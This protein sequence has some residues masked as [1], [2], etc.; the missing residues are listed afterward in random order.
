MTEPVRERLKTL[1]ARPG[2]YLMRDR[3]G[4]IVYVG[5]A[6]NLR[7]RVTGYFRAGAKHPPKVRSMVDT[8]WDFSFMTVKNEAEALL[9]EAALIKQHRPRFNIL[10]RDDKRYLALR[11]DTD[12]RWPRFSLTRTVRRDGA[13]Y[14]GPF[15]SGAAVRAAKDFAE[16]RF[17]IRSCKTPE[18]DAATHAHCLDDVVRTCSA[19]CIGK[20]CEAEYRRR[21]AEAC[22][23]LDGRR[24]AAVAEVADGMRAAS[25]RG[26]FE[27]AARL[28]DAWLALKEFGKSH[29]VRKPPGARREDAMRGLRELAD[30]LGLPAPPRTIECAD[31]SNLFGTYNV[32]SL[33]VAR[34]GLPDGRF[35]RRFRIS[36]FE[37]AD[38]PRA[39]AEV[40]RR[41][42]GPDST[43]AA[44]SPRAD[45]FICDGGI[46]QLNA[47]RAVFEE[48]GMGDMPAVG[49]AER[50]EEIVFDDGRPN[51]MLPRDSEALFVCTRLRD[52]AHR[53]AISYH[54]RLRGK[55]LRESVLDEVYG[56]GEAKKAAL[57]RH[58][59]SLAG[60][61]AAS[62]EE[63]AAAA[64]L[65]EATAKEVLAA[66]RRRPPSGNYGTIR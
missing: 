17:G 19:P 55:A 37:G 51:L 14:F 16:R 42:Y 41:R 47:A 64:G 18:P 45:L 44:T 60:I 2:C 5:K 43:I 49:L 25:A 57:F 9:T 26:D 39:M 4:T 1:P 34:D 59:G 27:T 58:F 35:Y 56:V 32:A 63:I 28:R 11:A 46:T 40:V 10:M 66:A 33:V 36:G 61:A 6:K 7:R 13:R 8:V 30:A 38:D 21:F 23:F 20:V 52:E 12:A 48:L 50:Q 3:A 54:R 24:P 29:F 65:P 31:I 53:F 22:E 62:A 15:P